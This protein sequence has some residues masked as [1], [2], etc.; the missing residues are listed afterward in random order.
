MRAL[1][2][3]SA[4]LDILGRPFVDSAHRDREGDILIEAGG[5]ACNVAFNLRR[6]GL[7]VRLLTAWGPS[8]IA[9]LMARHIK[10][11]GVELIADEVPGMRLAAFNGQLT[12]GGDLASAISS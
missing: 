4:H 5:T 1:V 12:A 2:A 8:A 7:P 11:T 9:Y 10:S 6:L 3:G